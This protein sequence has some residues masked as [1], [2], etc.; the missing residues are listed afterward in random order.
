MSPNPNGIY[1]SRL[2]FLE[3][4]EQGKKKKRDVEKSRQRPHYLAGV[5]A[6]EISHDTDTLP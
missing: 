3:S 4:E 6:F 2:L 1:T 5:W